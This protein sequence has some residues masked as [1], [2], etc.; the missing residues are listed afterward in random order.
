MTGFSY[1]FIFLFQDNLHIDNQLPWRAVSISR[2]CL[3]LKIQL[4]VCMTRQRSDKT[5]HEWSPKCGLETLSPIYSWILRISKLQK[6]IWLDFN[7]FYSRLWLFQ[8]PEL[9]ALIFIKNVLNRHI[10]RNYKTPS[11]FLKA[12]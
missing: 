1:G 4:I 10:S 7:M 8:V 2:F 9:A 11:S 6:T 12:A 5:N 3:V